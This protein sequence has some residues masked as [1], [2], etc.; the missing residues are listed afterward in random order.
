MVGQSF[1]SEPQPHLEE[2]RLPGSMSFPSLGQKSGP[3]RPSLCLIA[4]SRGCWMAGPHRVMR[5][6]LTLTTGAVR[7]AT[8]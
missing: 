7:A 5:L 6:A 2:D 1:D 4:N 3:P 8:E